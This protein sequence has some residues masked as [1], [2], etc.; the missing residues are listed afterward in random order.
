MEVIAF[1][2]PTGTGKSH[3]ALNVVHDHQIDALI[4]DGLLIKDGRI[5]AGYSA[6]REVNKI[7]AVK[8]ALFMDT[9]HATEV[10]AAIE[11]VK[12]T[13]LLIIGT[14]TNMVKRITQALALP[15]PTSVLR[16]SD[17][18]TPQ[19]IEQARRVRQQEKKHVIPVPTVEVK[20]QFSGYLVEA[21]KIFR[22]R[23]AAP[24]VK[25]GEQSIV[26]PVFSYL[27]KLIVSDSV[28][29]TLVKRVALDEPRIPEVKWVE[30]S[31]QREGVIINL[32]VVVIYGDRFV[33][34][35]SRVQRRI[36]E[37]VEYWTG[38]NILQL[39]ITAGGLTF[40]EKKPR[41]VR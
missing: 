10:K 20:K 22:F 1:V 23:P 15:D 18:A 16:I 14:S 21:M 36:V 6:K 29:A 11:Q 33:D 17:V 25:L 2:G 24:P 4:D 40:P 38:I 13:K 31:N 3:R 26:R 35:L 19:E 34:V 5:L 9:A 39:N 28:V 37:N 30:I 12:P 8:R 32:S 41:R 7:K 27:G